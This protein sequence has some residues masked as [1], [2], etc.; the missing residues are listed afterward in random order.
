M[1]LQIVNDNKLGSHVVRVNVP[2]QPLKIDSPP[3]QTKQFKIKTPYVPNFHRQAPLAYN[4]GEKPG[5]NNSYTNN[6]MKTTTKTEPTTHQ[7]PIDSLF[8][9]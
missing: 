1:S 9:L 4:P 6:F 7:S 3:H 5:P 8:R 2:I